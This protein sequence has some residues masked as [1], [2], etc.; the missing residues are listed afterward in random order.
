MDSVATQSLALQNIMG[1]GPG[2]T[3]TGPYN[4]GT[5]YTVNESATLN[6]NTYVCVSA[7]TGGTGP[8]VD[9]AHWAL[10]AVPGAVSFNSALV[11]LVNTLVSSA[12]AYTVS[13]TARRVGI[14]S[15]V[16][17]PQLLPCNV[18]VQD[19]VPSWLE[20]VAAGQFEALANNLSLVVTPLRWVDAWG[21]P[22]ISLIANIPSATILSWANSAVTLAAQFETLELTT[23]PA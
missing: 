13:V 18:R 23:L 10:A 17:N 16:L 4:A 12:H 19:I 7:V 22:A 2:I 6:G 8:G 9:T 15:G 5:A 20:V 14:L 3:A 11:N 21:N 1:S